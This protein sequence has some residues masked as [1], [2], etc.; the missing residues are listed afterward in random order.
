M[1]V[2]H[3]SPFVIL[4]YQKNNVFVTRD[5]H[6]KFQPDILNVIGNTPLVRLNNIPKSESIQCEMCKYLE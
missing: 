4:I 5:R 3:L 1:L 6:Q 2:M